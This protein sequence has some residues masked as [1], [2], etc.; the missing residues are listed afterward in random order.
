MS[1]KG[2]LIK[3]DKEEGKRAAVLSVDL[4]VSSTLGIATNRSILKQG[5]VN[6]K[7]VEE[8]GEKG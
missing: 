7:W 6:I 4:S 2:T 5:Q 1:G 8:L 3:H